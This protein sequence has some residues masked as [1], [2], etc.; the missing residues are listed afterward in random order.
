MPATH[1]IV[2][3]TG[4]YKDAFGATKK[5]YLRCG[6]AFTK[7]GNLS[8]KLDAIPGPGWNGWLS[9]YPIK[10]RDAEP[11]PEPR[12]APAPAPV[13]SDEDDDIPF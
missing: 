10:E 12:R 4:E 1:E 13:V 2:A 7:D 5:R 8:L 6:T 9:L 3:V 11:R